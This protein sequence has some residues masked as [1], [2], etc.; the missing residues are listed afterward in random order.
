MAHGSI[1][2]RGGTDEGTPRLTLVERGTEL[3]NLELS[4]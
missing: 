1:L 4:S 2:L 3:R